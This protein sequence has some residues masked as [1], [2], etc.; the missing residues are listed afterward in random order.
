VILGN[1]VEWIVEGLKALLAPHGDRVE[2][3]GTATGDPDL[4]VEALTSS[5]ADVLLIDAFSRSGDGVDA[6]SMVLATGPDFGVVIFTEATDLRHLF[7]ALRVGVRGYLLKSMSLDD[8]LVSLERI[9][10]GETVIDPTLATRAAVVAARTT[11]HQRWLG[12]HLG[13]SQRESEV[14]QL[15]AR[16][17]RIDDIGRELTIG[18]ETVRSH[19][20]Q[21]YRKL[22]VNDRAA[23][24]ATAWREGMG[25]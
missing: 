6:A 13:L 9:A 1:D 10:D 7:A 20:R 12:A 18:R 15:L 16:G 3:V 4:L 14:L 21:I 17:Q 23:A 22:G 8:L 5:E 24:V 11:A 25:S 19:I 2:V